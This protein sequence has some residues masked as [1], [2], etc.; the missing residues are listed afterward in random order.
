ME[1]A[2]ITLAGTLSVL[3]LIYGGYL[4]LSQLSATDDEFANEESSDFPVSEA[5]QR[6]TLR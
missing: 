4:V 2:L 6:P 5:T 3:L 1:H